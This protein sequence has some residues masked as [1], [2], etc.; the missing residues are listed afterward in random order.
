MSSSKYLYVDLIY[1]G[2]INN[3]KVISYDKINELIID[4]RTLLYSKHVDQ[5]SKKHNYEVLTLEYE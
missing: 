2:I 3:N 1:L 5:L 4:C